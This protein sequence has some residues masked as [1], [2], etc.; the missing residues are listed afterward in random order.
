ML[1]IIAAAA[2]GSAS[3]AYA[4]GHYVNGYVTKNGTY[5]APHYQSNPDAYQSNNYSTRGNVNPYSGEV[6]TRNTYGYNN[7]YSNNNGLE[8]LPD[9]GN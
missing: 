5:V 7:G 6:G 9:Y 3:V 1:I 4:G 2:V 8:P